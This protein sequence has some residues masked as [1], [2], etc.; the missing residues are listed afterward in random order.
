[1]YEQFP[2]LD[3][4]IIA[5]EKA[6]YSDDGTPF[7]AFCRRVISPVEFLCTEVLYGYWILLSFTVL[8]L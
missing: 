2:Y 7:K 5:I 3:Y 6:P 4:N 1:M 8:T